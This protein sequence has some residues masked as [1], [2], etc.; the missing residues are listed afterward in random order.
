MHSLLSPHAHHC[1]RAI[2]RMWMHPL[3]RENNASLKP[4]KPRH[5]IGQ[6]NPIV[7]SS[8]VLPE[9]PANRTLKVFVFEQISC[10]LFVLFFL[11]FS[12]KLNGVPC[13]KSALHVTIRVEDTVVTV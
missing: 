12:V 6:K 7:P 2:V 4:G 8:I 5:T 3:L 13:D 9:W 11:F 10:T 1:K